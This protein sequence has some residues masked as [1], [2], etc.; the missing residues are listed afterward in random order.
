MSAGNDSVSVR[1]LIYTP[2]PF[3]VN[4]LREPIIAQQFDDDEEVIINYC[5]FSIYWDYRHFKEY[6]DAVECDGCVICYTGFHPHMLGSDNYAFCRTDDKNK[7]LEE[8][9]YDKIFD[10]FIESIEESTLGSMLKIVGGKK[11][12]EPLK[13]PLIL[14]IKCIINASYS[15]FIFNGY[16][17]K[18]RGCYLAE[19]FGF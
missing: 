5:D 1:N 12:L 16:W 8:I 4:T 2:N 17:L 9:N 10:K 7:I 18:I 14:K 13:E 6:V 15:I 11:A 3:L 19:S